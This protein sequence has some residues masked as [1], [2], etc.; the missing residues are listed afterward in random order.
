MSNF[1]QAEERNFTLFKYVNELSNNIESLESQI[2]IMKTELTQ[3]TVGGHD[4]E[5][6]K[7]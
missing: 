2:A 6:L 3:H 1:I 4:E 5:D 7:K